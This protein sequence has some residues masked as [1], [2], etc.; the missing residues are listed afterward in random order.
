MAMA[1][2]SV[3]DAFVIVAQSVALGLHLGR[4]VLAVEA[5]AG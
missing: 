5:P 3:G 2:A 1:A 4:R